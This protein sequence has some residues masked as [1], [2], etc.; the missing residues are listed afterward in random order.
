M[1]KIKN[2]FG[3]IKADEQ[4]KNNTLAFLDS[5]RSEPVSRSRRKVIPFSLA[6]AAVLFLTIAAG[7]YEMWFVPVTVVSIDV[8][9]SVEISVNRL[10]RILSADAY[11]DDGTKILQSVSVKGMKYEEGI[12]DILSSD[13]FTQYLSDD[14]LLTFTVASKNDEKVIS[15]IQHCLSTTG[16]QGVCVNASSEA[17]SQAHHLGLSLGK[18]QAYLEISE[19][20]PTITAEE[21]NSMTMKELCELKEQL[22]GAETCDIPQEGSNQQNNESHGHGTEHRYGHR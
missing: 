21:C 18:Y 3:E 1:N 20:D 9:P 5:K 4:L 15:Q 17:V 2:A 8:N 6:A 19:Y 7:V 14:S 12:N 10:D 13:T 16:H 22:S 11:N